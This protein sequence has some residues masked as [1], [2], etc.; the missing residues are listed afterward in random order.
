M[1]KK[2]IIIS[3]SCLAILAIALA[4][5][6]FFWVM[7]RPTPSTVLYVDPQTVGRTIGQDF[8]IYINV[9]SVT[10]LFGWRL[11][12]RWN[13]TILDAVTVTEGTFLRSHGNTFFYQTINET[14][15]LVLDCT[16]LGDVSGVNGSGVLATI[17]FHVKENG[18]C[19]LKLYDTMLLDSSSD[20]INHVVR[21][22]RFST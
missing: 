3:V 21:D 14:G 13:T 16:L 9:S 10:D 7:N 19:D 20:L 12:L 4:L 1:K 17:Q 15:Y 5:I 22:G 11:K 2:T 18:S 6:I 8:T